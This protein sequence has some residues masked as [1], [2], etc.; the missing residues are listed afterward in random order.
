MHGN[1]GPVRRTRIV[2]RDDS[3]T[4]IES[5]IL[6]EHWPDVDLLAKLL[7]HRKATAMRHMAKRCGLIPDKV[8]NVWTGA[9]DS[10]LRRFAAQGIDR[11]TIAQE[12]GLTVQ[13]VANRL[14]YRKLNLAKRPPLPTGNDLA[15][16]IRRR[17]FDLRM[18][19]VDLDRSLGGKKVFQNCYKGRKKRIPAARIQQAVSALGGRLLIEWI[20]E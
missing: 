2:R 20:G 17:A 13:Q 11:K 18:T 14:N 7:P 9:Q 3:W 5:E 8:Q 19:T 15:D 1:P 10:K 6:R 4:F 12:L 16:A